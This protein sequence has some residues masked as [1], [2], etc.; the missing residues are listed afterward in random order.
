MN[1]EIDLKNKSIVVLTEGGRTLG[2]GHISRTISITNI[3]K[4]NNFKRNF[5][6]YG[7][8]SLEKILKN[9]NYELFNWLEDNTLIDKIKNSDFI[10]I[11]SILVSNSK[12]KLIESLGIPIIFIDDEK[13][14][15][16]LDTG[17]VIDWTILS[18]EKDYFIP[19]KDK[20]KYLLGSQ[21]TPLRN[22]FNSNDKLLINDQ[23]K[24]ILITFGGSDIRNLTP[25]ILKILN[26]KFPNIIKNIVI[27][28]GYENNEDIIL[29]K[30]NNTNLIYN[31]TEDKMCHLMKTNDL[32]IASGGQTLYELALIGIPTIAIIIVNNAK[33]DTQGWDKVG[34]VKNIGWYNDPNLEDQLVNNIIL[35]KDKK[36]RT[37]MQDQASKYIKPYGAKRVYDAII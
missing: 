23:I 15:N 31:A 36:T 11:D 12:I 16:I 35:C 32:A 14:R 20:V 17:Y 22:V 30:D 24:S 37:Y 28:S 9:K 7:D 33:D 13:R 19:K 8:D 27:G 1:L 4:N 6:I 3:F 10:L 5:I 26:E 34:F 29:C 2:F 25:K 21:Y 18:D